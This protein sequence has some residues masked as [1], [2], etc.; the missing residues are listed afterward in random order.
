MTGQQQQPAG[1][2]FGTRPSDFD[3]PQPPLDAAPELLE[4]LDVLYPEYEKRHGHTGITVL[5]AAIDARGDVIYGEVIKSCGYPV[6]D[7]SA[8]SALRNAWFK[9]AK[10]EG[11]QVAA[12]LT[13]PVQFTNIH[14]SDKHDVEKTN[15][16]L[17][18][19]VRTLEN[20]KRMLEEEQRKIEEEMKRLR[21][22]KA[23]GD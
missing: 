21:Q 4:P 18:D 15:D 9:A 19:D 22:R 10:R 17:R 23:K 2:S 5:A 13:I 1:L 14:T 20:S 12:R 6:L 3:R 7:S 11:R 16:E 8:L